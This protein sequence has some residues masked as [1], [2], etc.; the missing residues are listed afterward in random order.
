MMR[1]M[2]LLLVA[3]ICLVVCAT[4]GDDRIGLRL[5]GVAFNGAAIALNALVLGQILE[6]RR[7][8]D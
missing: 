6:F 7:K 2:V 5:I 4:F 3:F 8:K 1:Y